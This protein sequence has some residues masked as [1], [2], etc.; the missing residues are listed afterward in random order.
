[1][2]NEPWFKWWHW[3]VRPRRTWIMH[4]WL[5]EVQCQVQEEID[6]DAVGNYCSDMLMYGTA[7]YEAPDGS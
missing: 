6:E 3:I 5:K 2:E 4:K 7:I 1:M